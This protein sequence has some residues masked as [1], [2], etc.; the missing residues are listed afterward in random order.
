M[1]RNTM[2]NVFLPRPERRGVIK[3]LLF[4]LFFALPCWSV[5]VL[6]TLLTIPHTND[7]EKDGMFFET[8]LLSA[9]QI[10]LFLF[11]KF[12]AYSFVKNH[13]KDKFFVSV[14]EKLE[15]SG[16]ARVKFLLS[17]LAID[18]FL[19]LTMLGANIFLSAVDEV[20]TFI[21]RISAGG[22]FLCRGTFLI[23]LNFEKNPGVAKVLDKIYCSLFWIFFVV[24]YPLITAITNVYTD[25]PLLGNLEFNPIVLFLINSLIILSKP[26][27]IP[28]LERFSALPEFLKNTEP[29]HMAKLF[30]VACLLDILSLCINFSDDPTGPV[31]YLLAGGGIATMI[32]F[33]YLQK[34][35]PLKWFYASFYVFTVPSILFQIFI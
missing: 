7:P 26:L 29:K 8:L 28:V 5:I 21:F 15:K 17:G 24:S 4:N 25:A 19:Y 32:F 35:K 20:F 22:L 1:E 9:Y 3:Y 12:S 10:V 13:C 16:T 27:L 11:A 18:I 6:A 30:A 34:N 2:K 23:R 31:R 33:R 14:F